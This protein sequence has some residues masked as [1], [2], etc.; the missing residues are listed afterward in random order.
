MTYSEQLE[1]FDKKIREAQLAGN[2]SDFEN[3]TQMK[4]NWEGLCNA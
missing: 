2:F 3:Y 4:S 1:W